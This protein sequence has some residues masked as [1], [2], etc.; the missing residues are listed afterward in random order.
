MDFNKQT[1]KKGTGASETEG[2]TQGTYFVHDDIMISQIPNV[3]IRTIPTRKDEF[4]ENSSTHGGHGAVHS[5]ATNQLDQDQEK[6]LLEEMFQKG[7]VEPVDED[8][9]QQGKARDTVQQQYDPLEN[10]VPHLTEN[11]GEMLKSSEP[12]TNE[13]ELGG[14]FEESSLKLLALPVDSLHCIASFLP[15]VDWANFGLTTTSASPICRDVFTKVRVHGFRCAT[16][17]V[18]AWVSQ[19]QETEG[20]LSGSYFPHHKL[21]YVTL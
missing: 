20:K 15:A 1:S 21:I 19:S 18:T 7:A 8:K 4:V 12:D 9:D 6:Y 10:L 3:D 11:C 14:E 2:E 13:D 5:D 17:I 16:E